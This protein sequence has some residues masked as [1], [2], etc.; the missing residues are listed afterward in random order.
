M[1]P[2]R[3]CPIC[4]TGLVGKPVDGRNSLVCDGCG[5]INYLN[6]VPVAACLVSN[7]RSELLLVRRKIPP[8]EGKWGLPGGYIELDE[9]AAQA[10][11]RELEEET[12]IGGAFERYVGVEA[13]DSDIYGAVLVVG[14]E[15]R[16]LTWELSPGDDAMDAR[17]FA[18]KDIPE[19]PFKSHRQLIERFLSGRR[20]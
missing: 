15:L 3:F 7:E 11:V 20:S 19:I 5:W 14:V 18:V 8:C 2:Y 1:K 10:A 16:G 6:P 4:G 17:F 12:G 13:Q 9:T